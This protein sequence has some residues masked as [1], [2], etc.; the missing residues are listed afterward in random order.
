MKTQDII[1]YLKDVY[2]SFVEDLHFLD[3]CNGY[4]DGYVHALR[5][6]KLITRPQMEY[7][8]K[9]NNEETSRWLQIAKKDARLS[10]KEFDKV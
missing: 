6:N 10:M 5:K 9:W 7:L 1:T 8:E 4:G 2:F 3:Y